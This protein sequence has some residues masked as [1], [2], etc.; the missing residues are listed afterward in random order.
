MA[1]RLYLDVACTQ[2]IDELNPDIIHK[3]VV[4]GADMIDERSCGL[5]VMIQ[6]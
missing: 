2:E 4:A 5:R 6:H 1:L 3:A